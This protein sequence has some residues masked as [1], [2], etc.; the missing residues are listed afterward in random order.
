MTPGV[1]R[2]R[3]Q[4]QS[5][6]RR[7]VAPAPAVAY[8]EEHAS[9]APV[10]AR[11]DPVELASDRRRPWPE[12]LRA[13]VDLR[14]STAG[15]LDDLEREIVRQAQRSGASWGELALVYGTRRQ[16]AYERLSRLLRGR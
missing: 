1:G 10:R 8:C 2:R 12:R 6:Q 11:P 5:K 3:K 14:R 7:A 9:L 4:Q 15:Q 13:L 16:S